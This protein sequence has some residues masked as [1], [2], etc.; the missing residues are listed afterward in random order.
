[1][2]AQVQQT[3][4]AGADGTFLWGGF[5]TNELQDRSRSKIDEVLRHVPKGLGGVYQRLLQQIGDKEALV[6]ILQWVVLAARPLTLE[7]LTVVAGIKAAGTLPATQVTKDRLR[8]GGLLMKVEGDVVNLVHESAKEFF[9]SDQVSTKGIN[10]FHMSQNT[11][12]TPMQTCLAHVERGYGNP[13]RIHESDD[14]FL[15]YASQYW[16]VHFHHAIHVIDTPSEFSH[17]FFRFFLIDVDETATL[18]WSWNWLARLCA[19][20]RFGECTIK[21]SSLAYCGRRE[22]HNIIAGQGTLT[23]HPMKK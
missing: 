15:S 14:P 16:P 4:L 1:M 11:H 18:L 23:I 19:A 12:R 7:E 21:R 22:E 17:P 9:Q 3:L 8:F 5:V 20:S 6:P 2:V 13:G 10:M